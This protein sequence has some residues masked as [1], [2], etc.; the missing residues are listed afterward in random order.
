M[1]LGTALE[2]KLQE[3]QIIS[4]FPTPDWAVFNKILNSM[5]AIRKYEYWQLAILALGFKPMIIL[6]HLIARDIR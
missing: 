3:N 2:R 4:G 6:A 1:V 5:N